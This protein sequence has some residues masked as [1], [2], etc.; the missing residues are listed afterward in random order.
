MP[1]PPPRNYANRSH[2]FRHRTFTATVSDA[3]CIPIVNIAQILSTFNE[4]NNSILEEDDLKQITAALAVLSISG[5]EFIDR[6][7]RVYHNNNNAST[8][9]PRNQQ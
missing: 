2:A 4:A 1:V 7:N 3:L 6:H 8:A 9:S 5:M